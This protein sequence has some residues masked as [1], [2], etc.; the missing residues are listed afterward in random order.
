MILTDE[1]E[2]SLKK[3][4]D[5]LSKSNVPI[6]LFKDM[7]DAIINS[8]FSRLNDTITKGRYL[9]S[10]EKV[11]SYIGNV[12]YQKVYAGRDY[13]RLM[14]I[15]VEIYSVINSL[16]DARLYITD[17]DRQNTD[18]IVEILDSY[19]FAIYDLFDDA[20]KKDIAKNVYYYLRRKGT[21]DII[22]TL[23]NRL[24]FSHYTLN[25]YSLSL[26][27][28]KWVL[29]PDI[30]YK[31]KTMKNSKVHKNDIPVSSLDDVR[32]LLGLDNLDKIYGK[33]TVHR[34]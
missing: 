9:S 23:L 1:Q 18:V 3:I 24:G 20:T 12:I 28:N 31:S 22:A 6:Q 14:A 4:E 25:E 16:I 7:M 26:K 15:L 8:D 30:I 32:W 10:R 19:G 33:S 29:A 5:N 13:D 34:S 27:N 21:P 17:M 2:I 11:S